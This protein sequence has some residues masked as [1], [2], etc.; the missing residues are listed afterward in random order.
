M[1]QALLTMLPVA[2]PGVVLQRYT[3]V[4]VE[5]PNMNSL[6]RNLVV[7]LFLVQAFSP[8]SWSQLVNGRIISS[9]YSWERFDTVAV[10]N[11]LT[12]GF[13][14]ALIDVSQGNFSLHTHLQGAM[15]AGNGA[16]DQE[17]RTFFLYGTWKNIGN[18]VDLSFGR[19]PFYA[20]VGNGTLDGARVVTHVANNTY[21]VTLYG[22]ANVPTDLALKGWR[23]LKENYTVGGQILTSAIPHTRVGISYIRRLRELEAYWALRA[24]SLFNPI[25][26]Y[27]TP[28]PR[29]EQLG[30]VDA[31]YRIGVL[32]AYGRYDYDVNNKKTQRGQLSLQVG[33]TDDI[34][35]SAD[36]IH[37]APRLPFNS[38]FSVFEVSSL[39]E[40]EGGVDVLLLPRIRSYVRGAYVQYEGDNSF[41]YTV[42][43]ATDYASIAYRGNTGYAGELNSISVQGT[44][45]LFNRLLS[46][47]LGFSFYSYRLSSAAERVDAISGLIGATI[48]PAIPVSFDVQVQWLRNRIYENDV[49]VFGRL[50]YWFSEQISLL[51]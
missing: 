41:R 48:R 26:V 42:G 17:M 39:D 44:Y 33:I 28:D 3:H 45:P 20:G 23:R 32:S 7:A 31:S 4:L 16:G 29:K 12:R 34:A 21:R 15:T 10:S 37:R 14:S 25:Q 36:Y 22:G 30:S 43:V 8:P 49:R 40:V 11:R 51:D 50:N 9:V 1:A 24:D 6:F 19:L 5:G 46:P 2:Q 47:S 18:A 13:L 35:L 27:V 38:F